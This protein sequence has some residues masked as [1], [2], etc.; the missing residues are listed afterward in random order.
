MAWKFNDDQPIYK[1]ISE[2]LER[3]I[4]SGQY[5]PGDQLPSVR[6]LAVIAGVNPNTMQKGLSTAEQDGIIYSDRTRGRFVTE[7][8]TVIDNLRKEMSNDVIKKF[9][10]L[11]GALGMDR[12]EIVRA[13]KAWEEGGGR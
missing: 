11:M 6:D 4:I 2:R 5:K 7:D 9:F 12:D 13:V 10:E 8:K 1:Q 3:D